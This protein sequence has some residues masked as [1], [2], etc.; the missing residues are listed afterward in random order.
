[1][2][3]STLTIKSPAY[4]QKVQ[5]YII[6]NEYAHPTL[7]N[8]VNVDK[9]LL[10]YFG[11][12]SSS[13]K[14]KFTYKILGKT[15]NLPEI[16]GNRLMRML[17]IIDSISMSEDSVRYAT[18]ESIATVC[19][20]QDLLQIPWIKSSPF[21]NIYV[22][23]GGGHSIKD[24]SLYKI[25]EDTPQLAPVPPIRQSSTWEIADEGR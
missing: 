17:N 18:I 13:R 22:A 4:N 25:E 21:W 2:A 14:C 19:S 6:S 3:Q 1:M 9:I 5:E 15:M 12:R 8:L 10:E 7:S 23:Y 20:T 11:S 24:I 16:D